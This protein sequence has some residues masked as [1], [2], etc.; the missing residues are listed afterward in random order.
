[1]SKPMTKWNLLLCL[2]AGILL[3]T[4]CHKQTPTVEDGAAPKAKADAKTP[5]A[6]KPKI[7]GIL[8][9][10]DQFFRLVGYGMKEG[11][12][13]AGVDFLLGNSATALDKEIALVDNYVTSKVGAIVISPLSGEAS[14]PALKRAHDQGIKIITYNTSLKADFPESNI[15][16]DQA[17][18]GALTGKDACQYIQQKLGG[19]AKVAM[20]EFVSFEPETGGQRVNGFR[21]EIKK[22]PGVEIVAEQDAWLAPKAADVVENILT[23]HPD[24]NVIWAANEGGTVGAV[25][26]VR[27]SGKAGKVAV[28]G[29]DISEEMTDYLLAEDNIL[30]SVTGQRPYEIGS[31]AVE[32]AA[33]AIK[34]EK[35]EKKVALPGIL[36]TRAR[37]DEVKQ[38]KQYLQERS[39]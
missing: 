20:L 17:G 39:K 37:P 29:T 35:L 32:S 15:E 3:S 23:A 30:Q 28:F 6:V 5:A 11:A 22:L 18:L 10:E 8:F 25:T 19:K 33:M 16:S 7:A 21:E 4:G 31:M 27:N 13:K 36:F 38:Y 24:V 1:M 9:G 14:I 34:G 2:V 26:A 12:E